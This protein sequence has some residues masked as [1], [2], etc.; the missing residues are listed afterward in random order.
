[1][2]RKLL[3][4]AGAVALLVGSTMFTDRPSAAQEQVTFTVGVSQDVDSF[5]VTVGVLVVDYEMWNLQFATLTDKSADD[6]SVEPGLAESWEISDDGLT[7]TYTLREGLKWSDDTPLTAE[8][9][10]YTINR[11]REEEWA[12]HSSTVANI[13]AE[14]TDDRTVVLTSSVSDPKLP[15]MD[16]YIV[17]KHIYE[18]ISADD[19]SS[20]DGKDGVGSG[21]FVL[22]EHRE[23][24][25]F[26]ME[27]NPNWHG[28]EPAI[29]E[30]IFRYF[31]DPGQQYAALERGEVDAVDSI[32]GKLVEQAE[33]NDDIAVVSGNQGGFNE[34]GF[35]AGAGI[36]K[37]HPALEDVEVRRA[38]NYAVDRELLVERALDG[39]G[40]ATEVLP[41]S[42]T[43]KWEPELTDEERYGFD[44]DRANAILDEAGYLDT[45][46]D[47]IREMP[48]GTRPLEFRIAN[49]S[50]SPT[51]REITQFVTGWFEDI[52]VALTPE[53]YS[54]EELYPVLAEGDYDMF[55][56]EWV[57]FVDPDP[58]LSYFTCDQVTTDVDNALYNDALWCNEEYDALYEQQKVELDEPTRIE[59]VHEMLRIFHREAPY[60]V[61]WKSDDV[62][63][64]RSDRFHCFVRQPAETGP[65]LFTNTSPAYL[66]IRPVG[67]D[68]PEGPTYEA[69]ADNET[70]SG[71]TDTTAAD[72]DDGGS[73]NGGLIALVVAAVAV[74]GI[75]GF[76]LSRRKPAED[77]E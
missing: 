48:D 60:I 12:N 30:I 64:Y 71:S 11:A 22:T 32:D 72:D 24:Q 26:R 16:V 45:D 43:D 76:A 5:N 42:A 20:Y 7:V 73:S 36:E 49:R 34:I 68:C 47:G 17:P 56:W 41:V 29:D 35:N 74:V 77:R 70:G 40:Q 37:P 62:A 66:Y 2:V 53:Q 44:L 65:V 23:G 58:M 4:G 31:A 8:D 1:M 10:A 69:A 46:D 28:D 13:T 27:K 63:G 61:L 51:D 57:P 21:P 75:G 55:T 3:V 18:P 33:A 6:F 52:G 54:E 38:L 14:A 59:Q 39:F 50:D 67:E 25:F 15:V 9:V 19:L